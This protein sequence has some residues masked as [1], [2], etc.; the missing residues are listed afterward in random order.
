MNDI[1]LPIKD[2]ILLAGPQ[3]DHEDLCYEIE[4]LIQGVNVLQIPRRLN[5]Q[6]S[7]IAD[8][9]TGNDGGSSSPKTKSPSR[10][11]TTK[12]S[13]DMDASS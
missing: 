7:L 5:F 9:R 3:F 6:Q 12:N 8:T 2:K 13:M 1:N 10:R 4:A 11:L